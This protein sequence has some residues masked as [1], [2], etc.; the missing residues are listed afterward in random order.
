M[1]DGRVGDVGSFDFLAFHNGCDLL[2]DALFLSISIVFNVLLIRLT[3][4]NSTMGFTCGISLS[5]MGTGTRRIM[6]LKIEK[7][8]F[9][10]A[11]QASACTPFARGDSKSAAAEQV[12]ERPN[13]NA[14]TV[15]IVM[16][17]HTSLK[18]TTLPVPA[19]SV[20]KRNE[21]RSTI[22]VSPWCRLRMRCLEKNGF[23]AARRS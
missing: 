19:Y 4:V 5:I 10:C 20:A 22:S 15:S 8:V 14:V 2:P 11:Y 7:C 3:V 17:D 13:A 23:R 18:L 12:V 16:L 1:E 6:S 21:M 9:Q